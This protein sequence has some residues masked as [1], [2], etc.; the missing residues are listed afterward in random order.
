[1]SKTPLPPLLNRPCRRQYPC[2]LMLEYRLKYSEGELVV[3]GRSIIVPMIVQTLL[4][5]APK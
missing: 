4:V 1:M 5:S 3:G 2:T